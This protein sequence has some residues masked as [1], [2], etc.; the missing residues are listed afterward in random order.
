[1]K[2]I[3]S[4][5]FLLFF[6]LILLSCADNDENNESLTYKIDGNGGGCGSFI[7][8]KQTSNNLYAI[9]LKANA[10]SLDLSEEYKT[11][12]LSENKLNV[13]FYEF[14]NPVYSYFCD[15]VMESFETVKKEY[16]INTGSC[17]IMYYEKHGSIYDSVNN[18]ITTD[19]IATIFIKFKKLEFENDK[20]QIV[21]IEDFNMDSIYIGWL[22]G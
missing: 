4:L 7:V 20:N 9:S 19:I 1:M 11:F 10:D 21:K 14:D 15:D 8:Y 6:F 16:Q 5:T 2:I 17:D 3:S 13:I 22:P 12:D 18:K